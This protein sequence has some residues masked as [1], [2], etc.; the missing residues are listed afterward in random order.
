[1]SSKLKNF[2]ILVADHEITN[3]SRLGRYLKD[4][5]FDVRVISDG[6]QTQNAI[7]QW[8]PDFILI[9][10]M[11]HNYPAQQCLKFLNDKLMISETGSRVIV[12]SNHNHKA[13]VEQCLRMGASDFLVKPVSFLDVLSRLSLL[14]QSKQKVLDFKTIQDKELRQ[15]HYFLQLT[16]LMLRSAALASD[17]QKSYFQLIKMLALVTDAVRVSVIK[18]ANDESAEGF[19]MASSDDESLTNHRIDL[20]KYPEVKYVLRTQRPLFIENIEND[21]NMSFLSKLNK[22]IEFNSMILLPIFHHKQVVGVLSL[23]MPKEKKQFQDIE[24]R[25][26]KISSEIAS[27]LAQ[28]PNSVWTENFVA[29]AS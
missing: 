7:Q 20:P 4:S 3:A 12:L 9:D 28:A 22:S 23:R 21:A 19:V 25:F 27:I 18:A 1:M 11:F 8:R 6:I 17:N 10:L 16:E 2:K 29:K 15:T 14:A 5:G 13:N 24:I 26:A